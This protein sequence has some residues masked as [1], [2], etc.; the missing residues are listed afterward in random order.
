MSQVR[1]SLES[2]GKPTA[3][4]RDNDGWGYHKNKLLKRTYDQ[5]PE[6]ANQQV[7]DSGAPG[8][9]YNNDGYRGKRQWQERQRI[10]WGQEASRRPLMF[11]HVIH[12]LHTLASK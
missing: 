6:E 10:Q 8:R 3:Q 12:V 2:F 1:S 4:P 5:G 7:S 11:A 9:Y